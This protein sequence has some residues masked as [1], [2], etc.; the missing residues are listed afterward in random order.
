MNLDEYNFKLNNG[1][2]RVGDWLQARG[3]DFGSKGL[4]V[5]AF[6]PSSRRPDFV[7]MKVPSRKVWA[8][9]GCQPVTCPAHYIV[10]K[11]VNLDVMQFTGSKICEFDT[12]PEIG[13]EIR[14]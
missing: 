1:S 14:V 11:V 5:H 12:K 8:G 3:F 13:L 9:V 7:I 2:L 4:Q 10:L 6:Y